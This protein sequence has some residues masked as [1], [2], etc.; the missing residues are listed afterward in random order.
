M[1]KPDYNWFIENYCDS[2]E[3]IL[4]K[5]GGTDEFVRR[6]TEKANTVGR[7]DIQSLIGH[8]LYRALYEQ[9]RFGSISSILDDIHPLNTKPLGHPIRPF[10][11]QIK[12]DWDMFRDNEGLFPALGVSAFWCP[13]AVRHNRTQLDKMA[14]WAS[15][16]GMHYV[17]WFGAHDWAGGTD[18]QTANYFDLMAD[19]IQALAEHGLRSEITLF[20]RRHMIS[21]PEWFVSEWAKLIDSYRDHVLC[22]EIANEFNHQHN[23]WSEQEIRSL[24][25]TFK[26]LST[27][28]LALSAPCASDWDGIVESLSHLHDGS[29]ADVTSVHFPRRD[30][31]NEGPWRWVRQPWHSRWDIPNC[32]RLTVD[33]EHQRWDES[34]GGRIIEV[35]TSAPVAAFIAGCGASA[36]HDICGV[37]NNKGEYSD[38][39][40]AESLQ[41]VFRSVM[42][43]IPPDICRW[44]ETR[45]GSGGG[46]HP[47]PNLESEHWTHG[48]PSHGVS[49]AFAAVQ[50][51]KF[52]MLLSGVRD[53]VELSDVQSKEFQIISLK[54]GEQVYQGEGPVR[55]DENLG[56][57]FFV[58]TV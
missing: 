5:D 56:R 40:E 20:T 38:L 35:A 18:A 43:L 52:A 28:P 8:C 27:A 21:D 24:S 49:R 39:P 7:T 50:H 41:R 13:W 53:Y 42:P 31:T 14:E 34:N 4:L 46:P 19:T 9:D 57:A 29:P 32:P 6:V 30:N 3:L 12:A 1:N 33:N 44:Q 26:E 54:N 47:F 36:H 25:I 2:A 22:V 23:G 37:H 11:G 10:S 45:V 51:D 58:V 55:L 48:G 16:C 15:A 17:R